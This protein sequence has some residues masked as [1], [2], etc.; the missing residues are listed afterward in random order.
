[1]INVT[2]DIS[3]TA[4]ISFTEGEL[5]ALDALVGYGITEFLKVFY[6]NLGEAYLKPYEKNV[7]ELFIKI[8]QTVP[9]ALHKVDNARRILRGE[10][11]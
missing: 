9:Q 11:K 8:N 7:R 2:T 6:E 1:M 4:T 3:V 10:I 5:K